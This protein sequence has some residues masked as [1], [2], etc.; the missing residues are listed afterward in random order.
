MS[1]PILI[2]DLQLAGTGGSATNEQIMGCFN[3]QNGTTCESFE[4]YTPPKKDTTAC[5]A[6]TCCIWS[7]IKDDLVPL[8]TE[9]D[10]TCND[11]ARA[12]VR[13]GFH[14]AGT[15]K[16][17]M[18]SGGAD[19]SLLL[20]PSEVQRSE[21]AG[22]DRARNALL[23]VWQKYK[24]YGIS[25]ADLVQFAHNVAVVVCPLGPRSLTYVG[26]PDWTEGAG[27][28]PIVPH[29]RVCDDTILNLNQQ[30]HTISFRTQR[31]QPTTLSTFSPTRPSLRSSL[32][33]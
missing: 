24:S 23:P 13:F 9:C 2:G 6:D 5:E 26:R 27:G 18:T 17:G 19:G 21:N 3:N 25:A 16:I 14:D 32:S 30:A 8:F 20:D 4:T 11:V 29:R 7:Y 12:S 33:L 15:W 31:T 28:K 22:L 10:G 1:A